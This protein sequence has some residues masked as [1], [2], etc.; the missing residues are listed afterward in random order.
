MICVA[1]PRY[2]DASDDFAAR[3]RIMTTLVDD[4]R[5]MKKNTSDQTKRSYLSVLPPTLDVKMLMVVTSLNADQVFHSSDFDSLQSSRLRET[6]IG[7]D[8]ILFENNNTT[9]LF[10]SD[11]Q[12]LQSTASV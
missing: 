9:R 10:E 3:M 8:S 4:A 2:L 7:F 11:M 12:Q 1:A 6:P 5:L